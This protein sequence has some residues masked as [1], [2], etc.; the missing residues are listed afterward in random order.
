[1][2]AV[3]GALAGFAAFALGRVAPHPI[4]AA[5]ALG[6][7]VLA[8]GALHLDGFL[9]GCD[10][11]FASVAPA[12]RLEILKDPHHGSFALAGL[13]CAGTMWFA[14]LL[15]LAPATY[16]ATL[17]FAAALSRAAAVANAPAF[18][19]PG[20][21]MP[22][23]P[24]VLVAFALCGAAFWLHPIAVVI[25]PCAFAVSLVLGRWIAGR[26]DGTFPGDGYGFIIVVLEIATLGALAIVGAGTAA[27]RG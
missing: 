2:G 8:T 23:V 17:A 11:L 14:A 24:L 22:L 16:P 21:R 6:A 20:G 9:D 1:V 15:A 5:F 10:A 12:R 19:R 18:P 4:A 27:G 3:I 7:S 25:V 13:L 26:L